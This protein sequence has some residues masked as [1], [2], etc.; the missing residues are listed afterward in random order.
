MPKKTGFDADAV[1]SAIAQD[2]KVLCCSQQEIPPSQHE[3]ERAYARVTGRWVSIRGDLEHWLHLD[4]G[5]PADTATW[6]V[7]QLESFLSRLQCWYGKA[8]NDPDLP[9][10]AAMRRFTEHLLVAEGIELEAEGRK[11]LALVNKLRRHSFRPSHKQQAL[12]DFINGEPA[13]S[14]Q[15]L[16]EPKV[17][18]NSFKSLQENLNE[19]MEVGRVTKTANG[20]L[21]QDPT[22]VAVD[23]GIAALVQSRLIADSIVLAAQNEYHDAARGKENPKQV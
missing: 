12:L 18:F 3:A 9:M 1:L 13:T 8:A 20:Y 14:R 10:D 21:S 2:L 15:L 23:A 5:L 4:V 7:N 16:D 17:P 22:A 11:M 19:L 6:A